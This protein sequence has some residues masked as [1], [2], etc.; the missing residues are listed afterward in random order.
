MKR[1][2]RLFSIWAGARQNLQSML[3]EF[4]WGFSST[5]SLFV[6]LRAVACA[7]LLIGINGC[8]VLRELFPESQ[9]RD[10]GALIVPR[11]KSE[12]TE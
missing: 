8:V 5:R 10:I 1:S 9:V 3:A 7:A 6:R 4:F 11:G 2:M 12:P